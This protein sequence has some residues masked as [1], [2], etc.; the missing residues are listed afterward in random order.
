MRPRVA[1][2]FCCA[3]GAAVGLHQAGFEVVGF[4]IRVSKNYPFEVHQANALDV[5][6]S[7]F[8]FVWASPP[9]QAHTQLKVTSSNVH[10]CFIDRTRDK[11]ISAGKPWIME[12]VPNA[13]LIDPVKLD[14]HMFGLGIVRQRWFESSHFLFS[15][16]PVS[17]KRRGQQIHF[18][19]HEYVS[20]ADLRAAMGIEHYMNR[21]E[22]RQ[23]IPPMYSFYLAN[24]IKQ[25]AFDEGAQRTAPPQR[26]RGGQVRVAL[27]PSTNRGGKSLS[28]DRGVFA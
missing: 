19:G 11:L 18:A 6:L 24:Q 1:D 7:D 26:E 20:D 5:D 3:G 23:A 14:G 27:P 13:P 22:S 16:S 17:R 15:P 28:Q 4:D 10:E 25:F 9:C 2:L 12:N 21:Y 8:D